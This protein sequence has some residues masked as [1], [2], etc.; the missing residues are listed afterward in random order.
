MSAMPSPSCVVVFI[1]WMLIFESASTALIAYQ[2]APIVGADV[3]V[4]RKRL[5]A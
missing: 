1:A 2:A 3:D 5:V 4:H